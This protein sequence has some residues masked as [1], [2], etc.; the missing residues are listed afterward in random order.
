MTESKY[1]LLP[2]DWIVAAYNLIFAGVWLTQLTT[3]WFAP[4]LFV[5]HAV[6]AALPRILRWAPAELRR[7]P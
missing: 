2:V 4:L 1:S 3:V 5:A 6:G 7:P